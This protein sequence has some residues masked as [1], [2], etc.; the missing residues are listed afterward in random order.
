[1]ID[2]PYDTDAEFDPEG[3]KTQWE[4]FAHYVRHLRQKA[5][6]EGEDY[7]VFYLGRHGQ[8]WHNVAESYYG[9][10]EWD[11]SLFIFVFVASAILLSLPYPSH[12]ARVAFASLSLAVLCH[13]TVVYRRRVLSVQFHAIPSSSLVVMSSI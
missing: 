6:I 9:T 5:E 10:E 8:G 13:S 3:K 2:R 4:R 1:M 7:R 12:S 11:V